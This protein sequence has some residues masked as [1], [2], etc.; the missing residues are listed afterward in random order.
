[1]HKKNNWRLEEVYFDIEDFYWLQTNIKQKQLEGK[2][3]N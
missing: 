3:Q 1:M 2:A